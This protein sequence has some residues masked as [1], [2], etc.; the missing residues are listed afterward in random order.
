M[1]VPEVERTTFTAVAIR[2]R[3]QRLRARAG[4]RLHRIYLHDD[5]IYAV[6]R[7]RDGLPPNAPISDQQADE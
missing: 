4:L 3:A 6:L 2:K 5:L 1:S 7:Q